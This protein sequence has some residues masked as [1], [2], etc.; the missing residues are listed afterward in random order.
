[1]RKSKKLLELDWIGSS[2]KDLMSLP[3][4]VVDTFGYALHLAQEGKKHENTKVLKGFSGA[5]VVEIIEDHIGEA[6]RAV[7]TVKF[8]GVVY[9]LHCFHKKSTSGIKTPKKDMDLITERLK[10]A[11]RR[12][13]ARKVE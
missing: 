8:N 9:V 6:Y 7:Y 4:S 10:E 3:A 13:L 2:H 1:M 12:Y 5:G 11:K